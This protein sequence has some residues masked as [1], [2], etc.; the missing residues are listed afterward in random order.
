MKDG[1][2]KYGENAYGVGGDII[3]TKSDFNVKTEFVSDPD[4]TA[5]WKIRTTLT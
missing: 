3:C 2:E 1:V 5:V 4:Y